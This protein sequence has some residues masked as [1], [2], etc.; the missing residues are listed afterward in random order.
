M[1]NESKPELV[2]A[3][4]AQA[5][6][7][8]DIDKW[9]YAHGEWKIGE[10]K[11]TQSNNK[12]ITRTFQNINDSDY[13][14]VFKMRLSQ[15]NPEMPGEAKFIYSDADKNE[16]YRID[17]MYG[18][19]VC[20]VTAGKFQF[21]TILELVYEKEYLIK[22]SVKDN[23]LTIYVDGMRIVYNYGFGKRSN[24]FVGLGSWTASVEFWDIDIRP[25]QQTKCFIIMPFDE[26]RNLLYDYV[27]K[28]AL[29]KHPTFIFDYKRAD[30]ALT[31][32]RISE[33][34]TEYINTADVLI[35]DIT[36]TNA[37]VFYELGYAHAKLCKA[38]LLIEEVKGVKLTIPFVNKYRRR[39][40]VSGVQ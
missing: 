12:G 20:R 18:F 22:I 14:A 9:T 33:E 37:N 36:S 24:G 19:G 34:I 31:V 40:L 38:L 1:Q 39:K 6:N 17:F 10:G 35:A 16:D 32:G 15:T 30:E 29:D 23:L 8:A 5:K 26:K 3:K 4:T 21:N 2:A 28:P 27:I 11:L 25:F 13:I 7:L